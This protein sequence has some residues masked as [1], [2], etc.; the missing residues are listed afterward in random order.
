MK[1]LFLL[2]IPVIILSSCGGGKKS[3]AEELVK[4]KM[5]RADLDKK[6]AELEV[7]KSDSTKVTPVT[8]MTV[9]SG[10]FTAS[11]E[12]QSE[13]AGDENITVSSQAPGTVKSISVHAGEKVAKGQVMA[14]LD[15]GPVE[16]QIEAQNAQLSLLKSLYEK[17]QNLWS[18]NI[19]TEV[20]LL[21]AKTN[22]E[23][24][25]KQLAGLKA[26]RDMYRVVSPI[27]GTVDEVNLKVGEVAN[28]GMNGIRVV[29]YDKLKAEAKLGE[30][31]IGQVKQGDPVTIL[32]PTIHDSIKTSISYVA[33]SVEELSRSFLVQVRLNDNSKLR[34]NMSCIMKIGNYTNPSAIVVPVSVIQKTGDGNMIYIADGNKAKSVKVTT[35]RNS[36]GQVE[37]TSGLKNGDQ[38]ITAGYEEVENGQKIVIQ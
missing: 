38:V 22:Y 37:V 12:V 11:V 15:A 30:N 16:Q 36:N 35:G 14:I 7:G 34:P 8:V 23:A 3:P 18:Q 21:S 10:V 33:Q 31:Y 25:Q 2:L 32:L 19:G 9:K 4:L 27:S 20:Q 13:I 26:Q 29:S 1:R 5:Q 6:I 24:S 28:P 17:Q